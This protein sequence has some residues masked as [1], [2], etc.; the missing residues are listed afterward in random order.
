M[1]SVALE[2]KGELFT[3]LEVDGH[4]SSGQE[5]ALVCNSVSVLTQTFE[6]SV[7]RLVSEDGFTVE[8]S[9]GKSRMRRVSK[10]LRRKECDIL[11]PLVRN[12]LVGIK[13]VKEQFHGQ[14]TLELQKTKP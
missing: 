3:A 8:N 10:A 4:A 6:E 13:M 14:I 11:D 2:F 5:D 12:Y 9:K 1:I 7:L